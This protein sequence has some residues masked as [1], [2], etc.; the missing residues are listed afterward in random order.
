MDY[1]EAVCE[2]TLG[3]GAAGDLGGWVN[4]MA[5]QGQ[6]SGVAAVVSLN[7][8]C[9]ACEVRLYGAQCHCNIH[10]LLHDRHDG[11]GTSASI[12]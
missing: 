11:A 2:A 4:C 12:L 6:C 10:L 7:S 3:W 5:M 1:V 9:E 8:Y